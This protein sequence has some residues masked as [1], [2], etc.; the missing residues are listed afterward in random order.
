MTL[1]AGWA[2]LLGRLSGQEEVVIGTPVANRRRVEIEGLIGFFVNTLALRIDLRGAPRVGELLGRVKERTVEG[3]QNQDIPFEQVV[4]LLQT[5]RSLSHAPI[6]QV[7]FA[8]QNAPEGRLE[9]P[10]LTI[11]PMGAPSVTAIFDL[12]LSLQEKDQRIAGV[13]EYATALFDRGTVERWLGYWRRLLEGMA[14]EEDEVID[15][16]AL[17]GEEERRQVL[18]GWNETQA[19]YPKERCVHELFEEQMEKTP[20]AVAVVFE[21]MILS[22]GEL[23]RRANQLAY[24]LRELGVGPDARVG[25]CVERS[26]EMV[27]GLLAVLK[28]GGAYVP[29]D[30]AYPVERL[31]YMLADSAPVVLLANSAARVALSDR[32]PAI[33]ILDLDRDAAQWASQSELDPKWRDAG[34][35]ARSLAYIIYTSGSAGQP[36]GVMVD[37]GGVVNLLCSMQQIVSAGPGESVLALTTLAFD[38]AGLELYLPLIS[39]ARIE[40]AGSGNRHDPVALAERMA[41]AGVTAVQATP[42]TWRMLLDAGCSGM[43]GMKALCGGEE[44]PAEQARRIR[45]RVGKLWNV[46]GPTETT[47]WSTVAEIDAATL[48]EGVSHITIGRPIAN[49]SIYILDS[50]LCPAPIG[51]AAEMHIGGAGVAWGYLN[52]PELTAERFLPDPFSQ[53]GGGRIYKTGDL[54]RWLPG[55]QIE[56]LGRNDYQ[57]KIRGFRIELGEIEARLQQQPG[58][59]EAVVLAREDAPGEKRLVAYVAPHFSTSDEVAEDLSR[60]QVGEWSNLWGHTY[61]STE[62]VGEFGFDSRGWNSSYT[63][64]PIPGHEMRD[65]LDGQ[66]ARIERL[67]PRRVLEI[68]CGSGMILLNLAPRCEWYVGADLSAQTIEGLRREL[69]SRPE[70]YAKAQLLQAEATDLSQA[71]SGDYDTVILNSVAQYFPSLQY[72]EQVIEQAIERIGNTG[73]IFLGDVRHYGLLDAFH[74]SVQLYQARPEASLRDLAANISHKVRAESELL[75]DPA[76]FF[77]LKQRCARISQVQVI[78]KEARYE[79][80]MSAYRYDVVL[81]VGGDARPEPSVLWLDCEGCERAKLKELIAGASQ[82][83]VGLRFVPNPRVHASVLGLGRLEDEGLTTAGDLR[84]WMTDAPEMGMSCY[85]LAEYCAERGYAASFSWAPNHTHGEY[86]ALIGKQGVAP[87]FDWGGFQESELLMRPVNKDYANDPLRAKRMAALPRQLRE[88]LLKILPEHMVPAVYVTLEAMPQTPN[89]KLDRRALPAPEGDAYRR[90]EY[91]EP[92]GEIESALAQIWREV[93]QVERVGRNDHFFEL[94]GHSLLATQLV[95]RVQKVFHV[96]LPL[97]ELF[98]QPTIENISQRIMALPI[99]DEASELVP[100]PRDAY[101]VWS[102]DETPEFPEFLKVD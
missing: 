93:L 56:F 74:L 72:L 48:T 70:L 22:Y 10:G 50:H 99:A 20:E 27:V 7:M 34:P 55:G 40:L 45:E 32:L 88:S 81:W 18:E 19:E 57:V 68:G 79:N 46:Y 11:A 12:S 35:G 67:R 25:I 78:P 23:N 75:I 73:R 64:L 66:L 21:D 33:P 65:W 76:W 102:S 82:D 30:P 24:Y 49:T 69:A 6:F 94:G 97:R 38:I 44:L 41:R 4:E 62:V 28:A 89:G 96:E 3:Q 37:H 60:N 101:G 36:K 80:E 5:A 91:E 17:L 86:H 39:G 71:P 16:L 42:A 47:I 83:V 53:D 15:R 95:S 85:E 29:L 77:V 8:W 92:Q 43:E 61:E 52:R 98:E 54:S 87:E 1:L 59:R 51:V 100:I 90:R 14:A 84:A 26:L 31:Q 63:R 13:V 2:A 9:L 58:I